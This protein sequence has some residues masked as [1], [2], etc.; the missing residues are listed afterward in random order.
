MSETK[1]DHEKNEDESGD[2][3]KSEKS[4]IIE[5]AKEKAEEATKGAPGVFTTI[6]TA[7]KSYNIFALMVFICIFIVVA[8]VVNKEN[9]TKT[10]SIVLIIGSAYIITGSALRGMM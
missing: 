9:I 4:D 3:P 8:G 1:I 6:V 5:K 10:L 2:T 7:F